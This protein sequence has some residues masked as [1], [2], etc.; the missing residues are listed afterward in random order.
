MRSR[1]GAVRPANGLPIRNCPLWGAFL[2]VLL[3]LGGWVRVGVLSLMPKLR[4][5]IFDLNNRHSDVEVFATK[6]FAKIMVFRC[7]LLVPVL[8]FTSL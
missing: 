3:W 7:H 5:S 6:K 4:D 8:P 1:G 2:L